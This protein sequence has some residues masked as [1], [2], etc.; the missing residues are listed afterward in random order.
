MLTTRWEPMGSLWSEMGRFQE[1]MNRAFERFGMQRGDDR[2][3]PA[4]GYPALDLWQDAD[5]LYVEAELPGLN[6]DDL[7]IYVTAGNRLSLKGK[8]ELPSVEKGTWHRRERG[9]GEFARALTLPGDVDAERVEANFEN[10]I[11]TIT[12][13]KH[14]D[15]KPKR[16]T[17][18]SK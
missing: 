6:L 1:D 13:P 18:Q 14:E 17:I 4:A 3:R 10:G 15:S 8:R 11:L 5:N 7:E 12:L 2:R 9:H 16:I